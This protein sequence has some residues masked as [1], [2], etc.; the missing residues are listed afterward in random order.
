M[1]YFVGIGSRQTPEDILF[2]MTAISKYL[3]SKGWVLRSGGAMGADKAFEIGAVF[4]SQSK[5]EIFLG[6]DCT[7]EAIEFSSKFHPAWNR[8]KEYAKQLH[9]RNAMIVLGRNLDSPVNFVICWTPDGKDSGGTGQAIR[10]ANSREI[11]VLNLYDKEIR[12]KIWE[13]IKT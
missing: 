1:K 4:G 7:K 6:G 11:K 12:K 3:T 9:G 13:R 8:C 10:I 2:I 5:P